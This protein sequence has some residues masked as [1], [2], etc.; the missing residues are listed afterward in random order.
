MR[1]RFSPIEEPAYVL[2]DGEMREI[3]PTTVE[4][5]VR[6]RPTVLRFAWDR[7]ERVLYVD[8]RWEGRSLLGD[9][10]AAQA[11]AEIAREALLRAAEA[12][13]S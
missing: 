5:M 12:A 11:A 4:V 6:Q 9:P 7:H 1:V 8:E 2:V 3:W 13:S 10:E